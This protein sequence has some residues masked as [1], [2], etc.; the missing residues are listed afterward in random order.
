M[1]WPTTVVLGT[2]LSR[3]I[4]MTDSVIDAF[5]QR[6][7]QTL[8]LSTAPVGPVSNLRNWVESKG[9][10]ARAETAYL[11]HRQDILTLAA[12]EDSIISLLEALVEYLALCFNTWFAKAKP[13]PDSPRE[14]DIYNFPPLLM[15]RAVRAFLVPLVTFLLLTPVI[16]CNFIDGLTAR[17]VVVVLATTGFIA[18]LSCLTKIRAIDLTIAGAT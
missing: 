6:H 10:I 12:P 5:L 15:K 11:D 13:E 1:L 7:Q 16:I 9:S 14:S 8:A 3:L 2:D 17:L 18:A 4:K